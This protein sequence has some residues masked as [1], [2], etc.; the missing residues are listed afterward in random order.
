[1]YKQIEKELFHVHTRRCKHAENINDEEFV[2]KAIELGANRIVF[3]DHAPFPGNP[4]GHRMSIDELPEYIATTNKLKEQYKDKI[5]VLCGLETEYFPSFD[6]YICELK[7]TE[8]IDL[9]ILGQHMYELPDRPMEWSFS[10]EDKSQEHTY[11]AKAIIEGIDTGYFDVV[12]HPDRIFRRVKAWNDEC[13]YYSSLIKEA[14]EKKMVPLEKNYSSI[15]CKNLYRP[16]F[17]EDIENNT[18]I[19]EGID[20]HSLNELEAW[21]KQNK[22]W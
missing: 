21:V 22:R 17:W 18:C 2:K 4:F 15:I 1:M 9:L 19:V 10:L 7:K 20:A 16:E 6:K 8:G 13:N 5:E 3:T 14:A 12:A 11:L